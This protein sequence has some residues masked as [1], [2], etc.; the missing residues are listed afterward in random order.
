MLLQMNCRYT[1]LMRFLKPGVNIPLIWRGI[2]KIWCS[3]NYCKQAADPGETLLIG[4]QHFATN[5]VF[6]SDLM[7]EYQEQ[8]IFYCL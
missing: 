8:G 1:R 4:N 2:L 5:R 7:L 6:N 3:Y